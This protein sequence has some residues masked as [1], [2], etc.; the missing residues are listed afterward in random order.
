VPLSA[1]VIGVTLDG[2]NRVSATGNRI[3]GRSGSPPLALPEPGSTTLA[4]SMRGAWP[5]WMLP[6]SSTCGAPASTERGTSLRTC[7]YSS[8]CVTRSQ[9]GNAPTGQPSAIG[10]SA[11][12]RS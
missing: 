8:R 9:N 7:G 10:S 2:L 11:Q 5:I 4:D 1:T 12:R 6:S 3:H